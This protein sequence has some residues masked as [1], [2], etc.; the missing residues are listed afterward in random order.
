MITYSRSIQPPQNVYAEFNNFDK[1]EMKDFIAETHEEVQKAQKLLDEQFDVSQGGASARI[2][3]K[4]HV[5][6]PPLCKHF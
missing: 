5:M 1:D 2:V 6:L 3:R 4:A